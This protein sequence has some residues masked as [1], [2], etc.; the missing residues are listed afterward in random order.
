MIKP[1]LKSQV[2]I[3]FIVGII[4][5]IA[6]CIFS[7]NHVTRVIPYTPQVEPTTDL[8]YSVDIVELTDDSLVIIG[9]ASEPSAPL[10][11]YKTHILL[12]DED[13][14]FYKLPTQLQAKPNVYVSKVRLSKLK[15]PYEQYRIYILY[16]NNDEYI[17][18]DTDKY[19]Q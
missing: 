18:R 14:K 8:A 6:L 1:Q 10:N 5:I 16:E 2:L 9:W 12:K 19:V 17:L 4:A 11:T 13:E 7:F 3:L 15:Q